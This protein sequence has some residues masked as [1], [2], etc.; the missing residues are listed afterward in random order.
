MNKMHENIVF[1]AHLSRIWVIY[2]CLTIDKQ[3]LVIVQVKC[4]TVYIE[5]LSFCIF[6]GL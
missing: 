5:L 3:K 2:V 1:T 6:S 4:D